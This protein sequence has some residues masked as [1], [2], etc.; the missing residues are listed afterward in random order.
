M[1]TRGP[2][3]RSNVVRMREGNPDHASGE[4][5]AAGTGIALAPE[6]PSEP[7]WRHW[8]PGNGDEAKACRA[9]ARETWRTVVPTLDDQGLVARVDGAALT[10]LCVSQARL[11]SCER[12]ITR[13]GLWVKSE[14]GAVKNPALT[15]ANQYRTQ[16]RV[17]YAQM[18]MTP[19][20][21]ARA[22]PPA[23]GG[24]DGAGAAFD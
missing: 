2:I 14:R 17:L 13:S 5:L 9:T 20:S 8:F 15:A 11:M 7:D 19:A 21:R 6:A 16:L 10:D 22:V 4:R 1:G 3:G 12:E 18:L 23:T 24:P